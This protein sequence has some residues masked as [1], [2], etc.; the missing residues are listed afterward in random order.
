MGKEA[1]DRSQK[2][3]NIAKIAR[4]LSAAL[5]FYVGRVANVAKAANL[6][7]QSRTEQKLLGFCLKRQIALR[8]YVCF[9]YPLIF[10]VAN[11]TE[12][13]FRA[14]HDCN[15]ETRLHH[16]ELYTLLFANI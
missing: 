4:T 3:K 14:N 11:V 1:L 2:I 6:T 16:R 12:H 5:N 15:T 9:I 10:N 13:L 8:M 7:K